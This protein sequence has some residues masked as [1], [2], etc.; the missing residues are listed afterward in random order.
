MTAATKTLEG[1][2]GRCGRALVFLAA[3]TGAPGCCPHCGEET[4]LLPAPPRLESGVP[5]RAVIWMT[6]GL[7]VGLG[8]LLAAWLLLRQARG[9]LGARRPTPSSSVPTNAPPP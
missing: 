9:L 7:L 1:R 3:Q 8:G 4:L 2:C 6:V 5:R